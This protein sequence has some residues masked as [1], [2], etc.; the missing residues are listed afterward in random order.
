MQFRYLGRSGFKVSE[1]TYGNWLTHASQVENEQAIACVKASLEAGIT[2]FDTADVYANTGAE[3]VLGEALKGERRQSVEIF[4]KVFGPTGPKGHNDVGLS[5]K[6]IMESIDGSLTRLQTDYVDLYQAHRFDYFTPLE[7]TM[8]AFA[9]LVRRGKV[10]YVGVS[11][12]TADQLR[13]GAKLAKELG[14]QLI[15]NQPQYNAIWR[16]IEP[17]VVPTSKELGI[18]QIVWSPIAQGVLTGKYKPGQQPPEGTRATDTKGGAN[19]IS[20]W[21]R[22]DVLN[23]VQELEP[24]AK[25]LDLSLAQLAIAWVLQN[26]NV[27]SAI[28][29]ASRPEQ[30][31]ENVKASGVT[32]PL[33]LMERIDEVL[34]GVIER[35]PKRTQD[36]SPK[37]REV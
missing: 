16:V 33:P 30:V 7:E 35:D 27:A 14:F 9:D 2:T 12:W 15:S 32:I 29:G 6:H 3:S 37:Q 8:Q 13:E 24:I 23:S 17:E 34:G 22:D 5:R 25:E 36:S 10:L 11:E 4:T 18:S 28:I 21:M 31:H 19:M 1:I 20:R 26:D